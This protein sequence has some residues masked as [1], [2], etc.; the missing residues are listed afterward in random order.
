[1]NEE[2][3]PGLITDGVRLD[4]VT[5]MVGHEVPLMNTL[6]VPPLFAAAGTG[7]LV[8]MVVPDRHEMMREPMGYVLTT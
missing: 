2:V 6:S 5:T 1:M 8:S 3:F 7:V 4:L